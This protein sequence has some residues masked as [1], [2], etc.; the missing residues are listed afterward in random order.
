MLLLN[1]VVTG[2]DNIYLYHMR[3]TGSHV[4]IRVC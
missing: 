3:S 1:Y 4:L 2:Y